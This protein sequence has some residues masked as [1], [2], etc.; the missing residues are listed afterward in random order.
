MN[1]ITIVNFGKIKDTSLQELIGKYSEL[2][3]YYSKLEIKSYKDVGPRKIKLGDFKYDGQLVV[4][5]EKG[6]V[7]TTI[8][9][10]N[11][12]KNKFNL[13]GKITFVIGNAF[14]IEAEVLEKANLV[15]SLS[16]LTFPHELTQVILLE[17]LYRCLNLNQG[18][19]YHKD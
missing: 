10:A 6:K 2:V 8:E 18:G 12:F 7:Y 5:S 4:L 9:L 3:K 19:K 1:Q 14:G 15:L 11:L 16:P 13:E 17:Q